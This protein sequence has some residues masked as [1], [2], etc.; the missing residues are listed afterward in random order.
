MRLFTD[1]SAP[2]G[3][4]TQFS[5]CTDP[6]DCAAGYGCFGTAPS[7]CLRWC[8]GIGLSGTAAG[9][10]TGLTCYGFTT[11]IIVGGT[12]YGVCDL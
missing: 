6:E 3:T 9:C 1:C 8:T 10:A 11:P 12:Q 2:V 5:T 7:E 4:G